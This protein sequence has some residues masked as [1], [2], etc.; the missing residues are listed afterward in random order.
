MLSSVLNSELAIQVNIAIIKTFI[1]LREILG[2]HKKLAEK[3]EAL[4]K[5]YDAQFRVVFETM[6]RLMKEEEKPKPPI[7][8]HLRR[9][10]L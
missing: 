4:E 8:F 6:R 5:K 1:K 7:G 9:G 3:M 2:S 10:P